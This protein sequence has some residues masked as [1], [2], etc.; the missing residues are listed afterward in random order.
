MEEGDKQGRKSQKGKGVQDEFFHKGK[1]ELKV[2]ELFLRTGENEDAEQYKEIDSPPDGAGTAF[3][4][5]QPVFFVALAPFG[6]QEERYEC[7]GV[8]E[9]VAV[10]VEKVFGRPVGKG[11]ASLEVSGG[12]ADGL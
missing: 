3:D 10:A 11:K 12:I 6:K 7:K 5:L 9:R 4:D 1:S 2:D 8:D